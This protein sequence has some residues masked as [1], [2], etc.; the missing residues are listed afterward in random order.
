MGSEESGME[1]KGRSEWKSVEELGLKGDKEENWKC[2]VG[3]LRSNFIFLQEEEV[4]SL[5]WSKNSQSGKYTVKLGYKALAE[6]AFSGEKQ[7][8]WPT[9]WS[10]HA[11]LKMKIVMWL[12][13]QQKLLTL[14][15]GLRRGWVGPNRCSL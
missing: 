15:V 5:C 3:N 12:A 10:M 8:W 4:D 6:E 13:T 7:W 1:S 14:D 9:I 2:Y 11:P